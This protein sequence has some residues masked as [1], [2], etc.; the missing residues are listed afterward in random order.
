MAIVPFTPQTQPSAMDV[1]SG[2]GQAPDS[3]FML[4]A[5]AQMHGE[6]RLVDSTEKPKPNGKASHSR[7][8]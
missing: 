4:M 6:G 5:A 1:P 3:A 2:S 8:V 7:R